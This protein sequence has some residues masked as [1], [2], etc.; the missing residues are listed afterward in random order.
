MTQ[1]VMS[2]VS[3]PPIA[4]IQFFSVLLCFDI[5]VKL[6]KMGFD[7]RVKLILIR[8]IIPWDSNGHKGW[9]TLS[10]KSL[11]HVAGTSRWNNSPHVTRLI[12]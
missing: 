9:D 6:L 12:L 10:D 8:F 3:R 1:L 7:F 2:F 5:E 4:I 11:Q